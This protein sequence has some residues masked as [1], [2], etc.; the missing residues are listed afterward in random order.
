MARLPT[1]DCGRLGVRP[2]RRSCSRRRSCQAAGLLFLHL[3]KEAS[4][5]G[6]FFDG[7]VRVPEGA[8]ESFIRFPYFCEREGLCNDISD[9]SVGDGWWV[10]GSSALWPAPPDLCSTLALRKMAADR[11]SSSKLCLGVVWA[12]I[13]AASTIRCVSCEDWS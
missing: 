4:F 1:C 9:G 13:R 5:D 6:C 7:S 3:G 8:L 11:C 10:A 12:T 2:V